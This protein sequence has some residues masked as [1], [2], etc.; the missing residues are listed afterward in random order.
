PLLAGTP[1]GARR[2]DDPRE[3][4]AGAPR[5]PSLSTDEE[6][7]PRRPRASLRRRGAMISPASEGPRARRCSV[8]YVDGFVI[9]VKKDRL[10]DYKRIA[11]LGKTVWEEHGA[12]AYVECVAD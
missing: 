9:P 12:R 5:H 7:R 8:A 10:D 6:V 3:S 1:G 2:D 4:R 11:E